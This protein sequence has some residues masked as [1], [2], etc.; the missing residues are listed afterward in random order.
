MKIDI[1]CCNCYFD[2]YLLKINQD[3]GFLSTIKDT[4]KHDLI[5]S[6]DW[7]FIFVKFFFHACERCICEILKIGWVHYSKTAN[8]ILN[9]SWSLLKSQMFSDFNENCLE[10]NGVL[11]LFSHE[12][13][14][15]IERNL[16]AMQGEIMFIFNK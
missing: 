12:K 8:K 13:C 2:Y 5:N 3:P 14:W 16:L 15:Y 7:F 4:C 6:K 10:K 9:D 11:F 1:S